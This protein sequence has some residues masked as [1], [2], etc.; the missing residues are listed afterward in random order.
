M[1]TSAHPDGGAR[2]SAPPFG[3]ESGATVEDLPGGTYKLTAASR[4]LPIR[5]DLLVAVSAGEQGTLDLKP[6]NAGVSPA[7]FPAR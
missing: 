4:T 5:K 7:E 6:A 3:G 2:S 1:T